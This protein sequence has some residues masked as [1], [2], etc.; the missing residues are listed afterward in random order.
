[1]NRNDVDKFEK[2]Q[3]QLESLHAEVGALSKKSQNDALN[4]FKLKFV[5]QAL[6]DANNLLGDKY[7]PFADFMNFDESDIP[8]NSDVTMILG[9]YLNCMEKMRADNI[10]VSKEYDGNKYVYE[11]YWLI[12]KKKSD[13]ETKPPVKLGK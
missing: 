7:K 1:M 6:A 9:Q 12:D 5:N 4:K 13:I 3:A 2:T 11:W 10:V 8:T